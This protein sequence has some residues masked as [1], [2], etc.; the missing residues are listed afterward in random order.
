MVKLCHVKHYLCIMARKKWT[1][2]EE[3]TP[4]LLAAREKRKWQ[5]ALRRYVLEGNPSTRYAPYFGLDIKTL[6]H[7]FEHQFQKDMS[8]NNFGTKWQFEHHLP[9]SYFDFSLEK[10]LRLCW[11]FIN[12]RAESLETSISGRQNH[13]LRNAKAVFEKIHASTGNLIASQIL[14]KIGQI[15]SQPPPDPQ[16]QVA[17]LIQMRS[18][19]ASLHKYG[20]FEFELL[21]QGRSIEEVNKELESLKKLRF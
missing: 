14:E 20:E 11:N 12:L 15:E 13:S 9:V 7:W 21:N 10:D 17:F 5:I 1:P 16:T 4:E 8:W 6:R 18:D 19:L 2:R 3:V